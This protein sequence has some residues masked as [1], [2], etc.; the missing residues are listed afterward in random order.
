MSDTPET[1]AAER[2]MHSVPGKSVGFISSKLGRKLERDLNAATLALKTAGPDAEKALLDG[3]R[4]PEEASDAQAVVD[5]KTPSVASTAPVQSKGVAS[6][7]NEVG[8]GGSASPLT[9]GR[10]IPVVQAAAVSPVTGVASVAS[11]APTPHASPEDAGYV[12]E[13]APGDVLYGGGGFASGGS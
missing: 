1:D 9:A 3:G 13:Y 5:G 7:R 11:V 6:D 8:G 10:A 4:S 2:F 12:V